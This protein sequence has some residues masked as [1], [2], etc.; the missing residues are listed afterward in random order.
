MEDSLKESPFNFVDPG[1]Y[2][3]RRRKKIHWSEHDA[4]AHINNVQFARF[5]ETGRIL[6]L[7]GISSK[8]RDL[9]AFLVLARLEIDYLVEMRVLAEVRVGTQIK[10]T[11]VAF[12]HKILKGGN[13]IATAHSVVVHIDTNQR[14][15]LPINKGLHQDFL[16]QN[17]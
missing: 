1:N 3:L 4:T 10:P 13:F 15:L 12:G 11:S 17:C 2:H 16:K 5:I 14:R 7:H 8:A 9:S 6:F